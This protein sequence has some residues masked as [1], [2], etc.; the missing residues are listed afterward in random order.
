[1]IHYNSAKRWTKIKVTNQ[2]D[3]PVA[4][5]AP[6][7][8]DDG[9][10]EDIFEELEDPTEVIE[11]DFLEMDVALVWAVV[12]PVAPL[13]EPSSV[14]WVDKLCDMVEVLADVV[15]EERVLEAEETESELDNDVF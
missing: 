15:T 2:F 5:P 14:E 8:E 3:K 1:M 10:D 11:V 4:L 9:L 13:P 7:A 12:F 6:E